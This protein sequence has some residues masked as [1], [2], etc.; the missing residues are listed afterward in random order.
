MPVRDVIRQDANVRKLRRLIK[1]GNYALPV[2]E[3]I[4]ELETMYSSRKTR[5]LSVGDVTRRFER[6][7]M[8][9]VLENQ[10]N[11][12]RANEIKMRCEKTKFNLTRYTSKLKR[13]I[14]A[15]YADQLRG[16]RTKAERDDLIRSAMFEAEDSLLEINAVVQIADLAISDMD[17]TGRTIFNLIEMMK[18]LEQRGKQY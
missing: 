13:L 9:A 5:R 12:S 10:S 7:F 15:R 1:S 18:L 17:Q 6:N 11:R 2:T 14:S 4:R 3:W 16:I 8:A